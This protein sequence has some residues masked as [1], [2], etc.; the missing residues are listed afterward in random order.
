MSSGERSNQICTHSKYSELIWGPIWI[1]R[2]N[3][4]GRN[5]KKRS[6]VL[7]SWHLLCSLASFLTLYYD[8]CTSDS[9]FLF[10][11]S[12]RRKKSIEN[13]ALNLLVSYIKP[14]GP[15]HTTFS[16]FQLMNLWSTEPN[17]FSGFISPKPKGCPHYFLAIST[18]E[19][20]K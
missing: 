14:K 10:L 1:L 11:Y 2:Q 3:S 18:Y 8:S 4:S 19:L 9:C 20:L 7:P 16:G 13:F 15:V 6:S 17:Q 12:G 5:F